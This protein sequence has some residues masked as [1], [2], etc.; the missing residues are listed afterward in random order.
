MDLARQVLT[1]RANTYALVVSTE[2]ITQNMYKGTDR[3]MLIPNVL[4]RA[5]GAAILLTNKRS[6][7]RC[8]CHK[9][10]KGTVKECRCYWSQ[11]SNDITQARSHQMQLK[12]R[13]AH[14]E[15]CFHADC[16]CP[17]CVQALQVPAAAHSSHNTVCGC[18]CIPVLLGDG[19]CRG[20]PW[21]APQQGTD[22]GCR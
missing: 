18:N 19:G 15:T 20:L 21:C 4:F 3:S 13:P 22:Q 2:N 10:S 11:H 16:L 6:E 7:A 5:G 1:L 8:A 12:K 14:L 9:C 17:R